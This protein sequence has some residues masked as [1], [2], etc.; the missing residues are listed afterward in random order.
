MGYEAQI[1]LMFMF[2]K[3]AQLVQLRNC[4]PVM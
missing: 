2:R 3:D 4:L 1:C